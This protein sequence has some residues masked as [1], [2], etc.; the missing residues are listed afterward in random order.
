MRSRDHEYGYDENDEEREQYAAHPP[1]ETC[2]P[3]RG[4]G[5][6]VESRPG[7]AGPKRERRNVSPLCLGANGEAATGSPSGRCHLS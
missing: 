1:P 4:R 5:E 6:A 7:V 3:V 2:R